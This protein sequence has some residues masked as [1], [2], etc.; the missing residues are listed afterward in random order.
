MRDGD[1]AS[2][3]LRQYLS[4]VPSSILRRYA[5]DCLESSFTD[6]GLALQEIVNQIGHRLVFSVEHGR[7]RGIRAI[8]FDGIW[9]LSDGRSII[10]EVKTTD[11]YRIYLR[12]LTGYQ[13]ALKAAGKLEDQLSSMLIVVGR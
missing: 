5:S 11:A 10:V 13:G 4:V 6:S 2:T 3:E 12:T 9:S 7:Y 8:G 1:A